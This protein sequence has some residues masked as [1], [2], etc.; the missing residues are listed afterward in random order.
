MRSQI[1][2]WVCLWWTVVCAVYFAGIQEHEP[3]GFAGVFELDVYSHAGVRDQRR[4]RK[5]SHC[6]VR[7]LTNHGL[8][9]IV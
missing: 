4:G 2:K 7:V 9:C 3:E 5:G 1:R 6:H 8:L